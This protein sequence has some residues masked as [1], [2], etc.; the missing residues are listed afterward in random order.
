MAVNEDGGS[1]VFHYYL[2]RPD[3]RGGLAV[4]GRVKMP[5]HRVLRQR[6]GCLARW[7]LILPKRS[8]GLEEMSLI[9]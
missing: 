3:G 2:M 4:V 7:F 9:G 5:H 1:R 6:V 8:S